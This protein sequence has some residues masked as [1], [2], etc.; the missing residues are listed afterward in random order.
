M[1][2]RLI[3]LV[4][5]TLYF[6]FQANLGNAAAIE[7]DEDLRTVKL[8]DQ[9]DEFVVSLKQLEQG[10]KI[11]YQTCSS[12]HNGGRTKNNPNVTLGLADLEGAEPVRDNIASMVDYLKHPTS[13]DGEVDLSELHPNTTRTDLYAQMRNLS[14]EDLKVVSGYILV[15]PN[16]RGITWGAGK[17][18]N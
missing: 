7:I 16:I 14:E 6:V 10:Q 15:Q 11:F 13:Y 12:C 2:K 17:V 8:N 3:L 1:L 9:G 18:Y 5:T 4:F